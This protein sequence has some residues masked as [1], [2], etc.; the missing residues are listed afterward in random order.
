MQICFRC[1]KSPN[2]LLEK[3]SHAYG[4]SKNQ[5]INAIVQDALGQNPPH[6]KALSASKTEKEIL[7]QLRQ[8]NELLSRLLAETN[9]F[10]LHFYQKHTSQESNESFRLFRTELIG[11]LADISDR[12]DRIRKDMIP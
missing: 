7:T 4:I 11:Y 1:D 3:Y 10:Y 2:T 12:L 9:D 6:S 8:A 5:F